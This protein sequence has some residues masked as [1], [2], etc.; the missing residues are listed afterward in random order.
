LC[1]DTC[2]HPVSGGSQLQEQNHTLPVEGGSLPLLVVLPEQTPAPAVLVMHDINGA[3]AFYQDLTRRLAGAGYIAALPDLYFRQGALENPTREEVRE[4]AS[5]VVQEDALADIQA[6]L[7][8]LRDHG[9][10]TGRIGTIGMCWGGSMVMLAASR[11]PVPD[12]SVSF[13]GFPVRERT[14]NNPVL[15]IDEE[16]AV[17]IASPLLGFWGEEDSAVGM[18][19]VAAYD[20]KLQQYSKQHEF[21]RYPDV[22]HG[23][24]TFDPDSEAYAASQDAWERTL[25][26]LGQ[27]L[28]GATRA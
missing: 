27:H 20:Y 12:A 18:D 22:G 26:F 6:T 15:P 2:P 5:Q 11:E 24:L 3:N 19:N 8:W 17:G 14:P 13:Y 21:F 1:H 7:T 23:F 9:A 25:D 28:R 4:R 10:S 16:E